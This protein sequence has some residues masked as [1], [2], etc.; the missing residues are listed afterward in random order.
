MTW[1]N[2]CA[3]LVLLPNST[4]D[5]CVPCLREFP[6]TS[7]A[8]LISTSLLSL[9]LRGQALWLQASSPITDKTDLF[10]V[11]L[12]VCDLFLTFV[13]L[14]AMVDN[15]IFLQIF[16]YMWSFLVSLVTYGRPLFQGFL[17]LERFLAVLH[18]TIFLRY[19]PLR[20]RL[21]ILAPAWLSVLFISSV[22]VAV[23]VTHRDY[24]TQFLLFQC[25]LQL[26]SFLISTI[27]CLFI[28]GALIRPPPGDRWEQKGGNGAFLVCILVQ[29]YGVTCYLPMV[30]VTFGGHIWDERRICVVYIYN[31]WLILLSSCYFS[32]HHL[33]NMGR[34][35]WISSCRKT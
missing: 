35:T 16:Q 20:Y 8:A 21:A 11:N 13:S 22:T 24:I 4:T 9:P 5:P 17:C 6:Q 2:T 30:V 3:D 29:I 1:R 33:H 12:I 28:A 34:L 15:F 32:M 18:P 26:L 10:S 7:V 31:L 23:C 25:T 27:S 19:R 14:F